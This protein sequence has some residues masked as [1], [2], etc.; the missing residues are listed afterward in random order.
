M[1]ERVA[2]PEPMDCHKPASH[3]ALTGK[4]SGN[5]STGY[6]V[7]IL[8]DGQLYEC[9]LTN[10]SNPSVVHKHPKQREKQDLFA[11]KAVG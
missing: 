10:Q 6:Q 1:D 3:T 7:R 9:T 11:A 2:A 4:V 5:Q 8:N